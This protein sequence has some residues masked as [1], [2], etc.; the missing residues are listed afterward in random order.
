[1]LAIV[2]TGDD[3]QGTAETPPTIIEEVEVLHDH[4]VQLGDDYVCVVKLFRIERPQTR[5]ADNHFCR[6][7]IARRHPSSSEPFLIDIVASQRTS[8]YVEAEYCTWMLFTAEAGQSFL[9][10]H[11][12]AAL[13]ANGLPKQLQ[14]IHRSFYCPPDLAPA[15]L[16]DEAVS[17]CVPA[18]LRESGVFVT[19]KMLAL[20]DIHQAAPD[21]PLHQVVSAIRSAAE[22]DHWTVM[23]LPTLFDE[24]P[25]AIAEEDTVA[26]SLVYGLLDYLPQGSVLAH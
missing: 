6:V 26:H 4:E 22:R 12:Q 25:L 11:R 15:S 17:C 13:E 18:P 24:T 2:P 14:Q 7:R 3:E 5:V 20:R 23:D 1:M 16:I 9:E 21:L 19:S 8:W 10:A